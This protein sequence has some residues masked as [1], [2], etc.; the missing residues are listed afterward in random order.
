MDL[1]DA[2][3]SSVFNNS[4]IGVVIVDENTNI[5]SVNDYMFQY[6]KLNPKEYKGK[7]FGNVFGCSYVVDGDQICGSAEQCEI[8]DLRNGVLYY[9]S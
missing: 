3:F 2:Y 1:N 6:F 8:C 4:T 7:R 5:L 9:Y